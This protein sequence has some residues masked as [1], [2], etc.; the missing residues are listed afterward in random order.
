MGEDSARQHVTTLRDGTRV[1]L[2]PIQ[3]D[4]A[5]RLSEGLARLSPRSRYLR[6]HRDLE[7]FTPEQLA[8]LTEVDHHDHEAWVALDPDDLDAPGF[9]VAR[10]VR[11]ADE[12]TVAEAA[13]TVLDDVQGRGL[14]TLLFRQLAVSAIEHDIRTFRTYVLAEQEDVLEVF[15]QLGAQRKEV[16]PGVVQLDLALPDDPELVPVPG[17]RE[18]FREVAR[19]LL[20]PILWRLVLPD[21]LSG[22][23][24]RRARRTPS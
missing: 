9:G 17:M 5:W 11:L 7:S 4:D 12:P 10:Y 8:Y 15:G 21:E 24:P 14:G 13:V 2:R 16:E 3:P 1:L 18:L 19:G 20:P 23:A 22:T 6:F